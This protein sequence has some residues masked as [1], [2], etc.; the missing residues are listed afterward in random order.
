MHD[1]YEPPRGERNLIQLVT[2]RVEATPTAAYGSMPVD[3]DDVTK[4][5]KDIS[6]AEFGNAVDHAVEWLRGIL[7]EQIDYHETVGYTGPRDIRYAI[8]IV[9]A[10]KL[11]RKLLVPGPSLTVAAQKKLAESTKCKIWLYGGSFEKPV[12][13][14]ADAVLHWEVKVVGV[15]EVS[16]LIT[17]VRAPIY[18]WEKT[19][20]Q[21]KKYPC[22]VVHTS[23][24]TG[25]PKPVVYTHEALM[26]MDINTLMPEYLPGS[27]TFENLAPGCRYYSPLPTLHVSG[28]RQITKEDQD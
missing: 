5:F 9:A 12:R 3:E 2:Y 21:T 18:K 15:P 4:G 20:E 8:L 16:E 24:T 23:G 7:P 13:E 1:V 28:S 26:V 14:V 17:D 27:E 25:L 6:W 11:E 19:W 10:A 22:L